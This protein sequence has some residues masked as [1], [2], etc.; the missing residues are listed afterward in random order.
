MAS[1]GTSTRAA[2][3]R[4]VYESF[5]TG[6]MDTLRSLLASDITWHSPGQGAGPFHG[7]DALMGEFGRLFDDTGGTFRVSVNEVTEGDQTVVVLARATGTRGDKT[8]D[9]PYTHVFQ[10]RGDQVSE[11]WI[12]YYDQAA[13][14][15][16]WA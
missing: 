15:D 7:I 5:Q 4:R 9:Q 12:L 8:F 3:A 11:S 10:F 13:T 1:T 14:A 2:L 16:F 6:D